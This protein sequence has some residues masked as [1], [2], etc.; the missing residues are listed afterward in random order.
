LQHL[1]IGD[2]YSDLGFMSTTRDPFYKASE[3]QFGFILMKIRIPK[4]VKG[5][6]LCIENVSHF[7]T[8]QEILFSPLSKFKLI[9]RDSNTLYYHT[10]PKF[11]SQVNTRYE[12]EW[13]GNQKPIIKKPEYDGI[14]QEIDF[15]KIKSSETFSLD[16]KIKYFIDKY[17]DDMNK[18]IITIGKQKFLTCAE[19]YNSIGAYKDFYAINTDKGFSFYSIYKNYLVFF[20]EI[21]ETENGY[22]MH[23]NYYV[24]Y[25]T[26]NKED[27]FSSEEFINFIASVSYYFNIEVVYIYPEYKPCY[28]KKE[29]SNN[30]GQLSGNYCLDFYKYIKNNEKRFFMKNINQI[31]LKPVFDYF[32]LDLLKD[33]DV[34]KV[35]N[36]KDDEIYQLYIKSFSIDYPKAKL[37]D[38]FIWIIDNKCYLI[39]ILITKLERLYKKNNPFKN[40]NYI[41]N[42]YMYL[43]NKK[44]ISTYGGSSID[45]EFKERKQYKTITN[46]Y[47]IER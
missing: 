35:I 11:S 45:V 39:E 22:Q 37:S 30:V 25:N 19:K 12:F 42:A 43:Y 3:Y 46:E 32:D 41:F 38:F 27:I 26:L 2:I 16:E 10:D 40:D 36:K 14:T 7:P 24:K 13:I 28:T 33:T 29:I 1:K 34:L 44:I 4:N 20:I 31:E 21:G 17:T 6:A 23:V 18:F 47:R 8:E 15:F 5:V 9:S